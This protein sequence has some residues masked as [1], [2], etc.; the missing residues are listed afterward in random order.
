[1]LF[2]KEKRGDGR[3]YIIAKV[4]DGPNHIHFELKQS[5]SEFEA[6]HRVR[7]LRRKQFFDLAHWKEVKCRC[8]ELQG[9]C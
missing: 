9:F 2:E 7:E 4:G 5:L 8:Q 3:F 1:M 6:Q